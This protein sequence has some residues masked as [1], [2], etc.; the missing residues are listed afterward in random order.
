MPTLRIVSAAELRLDELAALFTD[1]FAGYLVPVTVSAA[2]F[3]ERVCAESIDL[4]S[5]VV[6]LREAPVALALVAR[7]GR[8]S[9]LASMGVIPSARRTGAAAALLARVLDD[10]RARGDR[11]LRLEVFETNLPARALYERA[12]FR[13]LARLVG[14]EGDAIVKQAAPLV[15]VDACELGRRVARDLPPLELP[16]QL[17]PTSL[18]VPPST[19]HAFTVDGSA[20]VLVSQVGPE[21]AWLRALHTLPAERRRGHATRLVGALAAQLHP[22]TLVFSALYPENLA[23]DVFARLGFRRAELAQLEMALAL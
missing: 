3:A 16:W 8:E 2:A 21:R 12:G 4:S 15:E 10:A 23:S 11:W 5:S 20:M 1:A 6:M 19:A 9:R 7:R 22:R 18:M 14:Y 13:P 17:E